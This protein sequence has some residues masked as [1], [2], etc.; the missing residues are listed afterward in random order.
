MD[1]I[2]VYVKDESIKLSSIQFNWQVESRVWIVKK[3]NVR[4][5][6][7]MLSAFCFVQHCLDK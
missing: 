5:W 3:K 7:R 6:A 2:L 4:S 1:F